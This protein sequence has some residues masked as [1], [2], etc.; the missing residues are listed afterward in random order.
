MMKGFLNVPKVKSNQIVDIAF[1]CMPMDIDILG[2][3]NNSEVPPKR[4]VGEM[5]ISASKIMRRIFSKGRN[6]LS[7][8]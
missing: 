5:H 6:G 4:R 7:C 2:H 8:G 3:M 1:R